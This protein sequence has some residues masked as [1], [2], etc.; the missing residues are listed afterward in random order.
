[1]FRADCDIR[2]SAREELT[3]GQPILNDLV[4]E[5]VDF[6]VCVIGD[7]PCIDRSGESTVRSHRID[8]E[9]ATHQPVTGL[10]H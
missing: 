8:I 4:G 3:N 9:V 2:A 6:A 7:R 5:P 10:H 1:M